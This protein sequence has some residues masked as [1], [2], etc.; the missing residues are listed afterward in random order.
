V[1]GGIPGA[2]PREVIVDLEDL[3]ALEALEEI[4]EQVTGGAPLP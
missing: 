3:E 4:V 2:Q 1:F